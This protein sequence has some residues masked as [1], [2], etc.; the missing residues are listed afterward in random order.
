[1]AKLRAITDYVNLLE[2]TASIMEFNRNDF[3]TVLRLAKKL[4]S[5][6]QEHK[7]DIGNELCTLDDVSVMPIGPFTIGVKDWANEVKCQLLY[8]GR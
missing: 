7:K 3:S 6:Y 1:M 4:D 5:Y 2:E 8:A